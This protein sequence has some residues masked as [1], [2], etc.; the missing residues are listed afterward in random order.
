MTGREYPARPIVGIGIA[1]IKG[2]S[3]LLCQRGTPPYPGSW[4]LPG[5]AQDVGETCEEAARRELEDT[6]D[7]L[8]VVATR[9]GLG[10]AESLRRVFQRHLGVPPDA[11]RRL[12]YKSPSR[13]ATSPPATDVLRAEATRGYDPRARQAPR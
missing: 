4:T 2:D 11:Y 5:G 13:C 12:I 6:A 9:C 7:T 1:V 3:V 10:S 8:D